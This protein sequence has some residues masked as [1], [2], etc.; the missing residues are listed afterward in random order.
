MTTG[1]IFFFQV[2]SRFQFW[3]QDT[4]SQGMMKKQDIVIVADDD[5]EVMTSAS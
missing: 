3:D 1:A 4:L 5:D 2:Y